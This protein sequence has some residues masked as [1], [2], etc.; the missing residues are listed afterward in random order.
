MGTDS[1]DNG[2]PGASCEPPSSTPQEG[3]S[4]LRE[5]LVGPEQEQL[6]RIQRRLDDPWLQAEDMS[7]ALPQAVTLSASR[8]EHLG[9]A[10]MPTVEQ[11]VLVSVRKDPRVLVDALFPVMGPAIRKAIASALRGMVE[12]LDKVLRQSFSIR[13][14][15]WRLEA[16][17]TGRPFAEVALLHSLVYRVEQVF[18]IHRQTGL[19][20]QHLVAD[21]AAVKDGDM[22]SGMLTAI[23]DF[24]K[25]SFNVPEGGELE[26]LE[27]GSL[28]VFVEQGPLAVL[29]AV[30]R[31]NAPEEFRSTLQATLEEIHLRQSEALNGFRGDSSPFD[32]V[33]DLLEDCL[34]AQ[35]QAPEGKTS[36]ATWAVVAALLL[37]LGFWVVSSVREGVRWNG[38]LDRLR[39]EEGLVVTSHGKLAGK[40]YVA[41]LR[42]PLAAD[43]AKILSET[44]LDPQ[45]VIGRWEQ[46]Q[47]L[48][49]RFVLARARDLLQAPETVTLKLQDGVLVGSGTAPTKWISE[50]ARL[51]PLLPGVSRFEHGRVLELEK[52][53]EEELRS[54]EGQVIRF[55]RGTSDYQPG[56]AACL[57]LLREKIRGLDQDARLSGRNVQILLVGH[58][59]SSG[60]ES[61][62]STL[63]LER[64]EKVQK[65]LINPDLRVTRFRAEGTGARQPLRPE[66]SDED[67]G[68]NRSVTFKISLSEPAR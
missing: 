38:Y 2:K 10:L 62:N 19:L 54:L 66:R 4:K 30:V 37:A 45:F 3:V 67:R 18:L 41:G 59:D 26:T 50:A 33:H 53:L 56:E 57:P 22:V 31:G 55:S 61:T 15:R 12:S 5:L 28:S 58:A 7:R 29:A 47:S 52:K 27:I 34:E 39:A 24:V 1:S 48:Q 11:A 35:Y 20:L 23:Q 32:A 9:R 60:M 17:R 63:S 6:A 16:L 51:A 65:E 14:L 43:P 40:H 36:P 8:G 25:D 44:S 21:H 46:Y 68:Y 49:P 64:A 42:D 13:G